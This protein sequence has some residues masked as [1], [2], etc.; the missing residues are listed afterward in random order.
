MKSA[1]LARKGTART[2]GRPGPS[3]GR[4]SARP[5]TP[6]KRVLRE[7]IRDQLIEDIL[8]GRLMP[9]DR[10]VEIRIAQRF[11]VSQ[12]P[13]REALRDLELLG[14]AESSPFRGTIVRKIS[15]EDLVQIYPIRAVLEGLAAHDAATRIGTA[16]LRRLEKLLEAMRSAAARGDTRGA[17]D[18]DFAFHFTI[19]KASGN[20]LLRQFWERM[21]LATTTFLTVSKSHRSLAE[22]AERHVP[23]LEAL[24]AQDP[25][26][27][28]QAMRRHIE[29][30]GQWLRVALEAE[31]QK[32]KRRLTTYSGRAI[33]QAR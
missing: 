9:G 2:L 13:V 16:G 23:V 1:R 3:A 10:M 11:G 31:G 21:R 25:V 17:V 20:W 14:F 22:I 12:A 29:E 15:V 24:R 5:H 18:A 8:N 26:A 7:E 19:V 32:V 4:A 30:P 27:A 28:E 33:R 6:E